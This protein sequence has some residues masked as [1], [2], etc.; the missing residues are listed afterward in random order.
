MM[1]FLV[2]FTMSPVN[3]Q[4]IF[5]FC[6]IRRSERTNKIMEDQYQVLLDVKLDVKE[7]KHELWQLRVS[8]A[9]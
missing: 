7:R 4:Y 3:R 9:I 6:L 1:F 8:D 5:L 2:A